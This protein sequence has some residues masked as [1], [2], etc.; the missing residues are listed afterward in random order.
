MDNAG[1]LMFTSEEGGVPVESSIPK[2]EHVA[3][4]IVTPR[5]DYGISQN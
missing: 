2:A 1:K 5:L 4:I 3:S